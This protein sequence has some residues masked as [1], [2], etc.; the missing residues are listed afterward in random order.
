ML[1]GPIS[2][3]FRS[4]G[5]GSGS[6]DTVLTRLSAWASGSVRISRARKARLSASQASGWVSS[7]IASTIR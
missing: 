3:T 1:R 4:S 5:I 2:T 6:R 7:L